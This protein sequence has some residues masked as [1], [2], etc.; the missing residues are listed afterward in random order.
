MWPFPPSLMF[1]KS[2]I[3]YTLY[4]RNSESWKKIFF[5]QVAMFTY[6]VVCA[7]IGEPGKET[8]QQD[9]LAFR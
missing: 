8:F 2:Q 5:L 4:P 7:Q 6:G 1:Y 3:F 9:S